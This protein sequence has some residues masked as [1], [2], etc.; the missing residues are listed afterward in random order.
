ILDEIGNKRTI[1]IQ[2]QFFSYFLGYYYFV[3]NF[4]FFNSWEFTFEQIRLESFFVI[5]RSNTFQKDSAEIIGCSND[6]AF[7]GN[8]LNMGNF[9]NRLEFGVKSLMNGNRIRIKR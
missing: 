4:I 8:C 7:Y 9:R 1:N 2:M 5:I 3:S 6:S